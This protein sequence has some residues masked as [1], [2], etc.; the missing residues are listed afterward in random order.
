MLAKQISTHKEIYCT[1][2]IPLSK[3]FQI[4]L[5]QKCSCIPIVESLAHKNIIG[6]VTEHDICLKT[7]T[8]G[9]NP[10]R[11]TAGRVMNCNIT[12]VSC[13]ANLEECA[14]LMKLTDSEKLF[15]VDEDGAFMGILSET[16]L[17]PV[18]MPADFETF[19]SNL[20]VAPVL[21]QEIQS[22]YK[23]H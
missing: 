10:Q 13:E 19:I 17:K 7:I 20:K 23:N 2:D 5:E 16:E 1:P 11:I 22:V 14:E 18:E 21:P 6:A 12:K 8:D 4:M 3:I 9:L 15:V